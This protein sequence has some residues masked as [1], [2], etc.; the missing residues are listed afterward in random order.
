M[1][2]LI[3]IESYQILRVGIIS[4]LTYSVLAKTLFYKG[5]KGNP[6]RD[7]TEQRTQR[8]LTK[9]WLRRGSLSHVD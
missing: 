4:E 2:N 6:R 5:R 7:L 1:R 9:V 3:D 8:G